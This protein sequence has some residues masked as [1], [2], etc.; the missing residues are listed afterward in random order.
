MC[1]SHD[2]KTI[3]EKKLIRSTKPKDE[4]SQIVSIIQTL[5]VAHI[6]LEKA[7]LHI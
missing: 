4:I 2:W 1:S 7:D 3:I 5:L 6:R